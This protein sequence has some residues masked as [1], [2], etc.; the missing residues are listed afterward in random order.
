M[1]QRPTIKIALVVEESVVIQ[2]PQAH[3]TIMISSKLFR[4]AF[5][6]YYVLQII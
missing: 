2:K 1:T 3:T 6:M 5:T 4:N